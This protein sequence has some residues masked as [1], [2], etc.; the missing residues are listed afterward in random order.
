MWKSPDIIS[1]TSQSCNTSNFSI[2]ISC[3]DVANE[4][5]MPRFDATLENSD[6]NIS[7]P[8]SLPSLA[9]ESG[10]EDL[11]LDHHPI[12]VDARASS[13]PRDTPDIGMDCGNFHNIRSRIS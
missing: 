2:E 10:G 3:D 13:I 8:K 9:D 4:M 1:K 5:L 12:R 7:T 11:V 6:E